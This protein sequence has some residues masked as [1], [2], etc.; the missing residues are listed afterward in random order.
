MLKPIIKDLLDYGKSLQEERGDNEVD[1]VGFNIN[2]ER[3]PAN[4]LLLQNP[5]AF[6]LAVIY[7]QGQKAE[8]SW[9]YPYEICKAINNDQPDNVTEGQL[10]KFVSSKNLIELD[11]VFISTEFK[12]RGWRT[13]CPDSIRAVKLILEE[14]DGKASQIWEKEDPCPRE[15]TKRLLKFSSIGQK[16]STMMPNILYRDLGWIDGNNLDEIDV[17]YDRHIRRVF[18]RTGLTNKDT[19]NAIVTTARELNPS[20]PGT[21]DLPAWRIGRDYC[22]NRDAKC[23]N[24]PLTQKCSDERKNRY[25]IR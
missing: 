11:R 22:D 1:F 5:F 17:S 25:H 18:L 16:K 4:K 23:D 21:L 19:L 12:L 6:L 24:C 14:Y 10:I 20:Y 15:I 8:Q 3:Q 9:R 13:A 2:P 7:D